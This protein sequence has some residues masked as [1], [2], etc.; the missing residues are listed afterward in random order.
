VTAF[1]AERVAPYKKVRA[2]E[3]VD[4]IPNPSGKI[5]RRVLIDRKRAA[6]PSGKRQSRSVL[7]ADR[8]VDAVASRLTA[9]AHVR[10]RPLLRFGQSGSAGCRERRAPGWPRRQ[11]APSGEAD[12]A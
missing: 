1:V 7:R 3:L 8:C 6:A 9:A 12:E 4:D 10:E 11:A 2:V 5:L